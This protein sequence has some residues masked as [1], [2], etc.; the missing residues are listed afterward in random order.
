MRIPVALQV[1]KYQYPTQQP[2][3]AMFFCLL[4]LILFITEFVN[5]YHNIFLGNHWIIVKISR[6]INKWSDLATPLTI[7]NGTSYSIDQTR[8]LSQRCCLPAVSCQFSVKS[9]NCQE[10]C[11]CLLSWFIYPLELIFS[12][13]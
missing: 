7:L 6:S 2:A 1:P 8:R 4:L 5:L 13:L 11:L 9:T 12:F 3:K 10:L